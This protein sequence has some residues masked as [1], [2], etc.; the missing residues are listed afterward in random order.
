MFQKKVFSVFTL[1]NPSKGQFKIFID[2]LKVHY[3]LCSI[4]EL[5]IGG[6]N[7]SYC[8][9]IT[10][11]DG[12]QDN[13]KLL[14]IIK[15][16]QIPTTI[17]VCPEIIKSNVP[18]WF[19][20]SDSEYLKTIDDEMRIK[21]INDLDSSLGKNALSI[22]YITAMKKYVSFQSHTLTHPILTHCTS[23]KSKN[24]IAESKNQLQLMIGKDINGFAYPAGYYN[25]EVIDQV[26][27][28][29]YQYAFTTDHGYN[30]NKTDIY[31][32]KR[33]SINDDFTEKELAV[34]VSGIWGF[35]KKIL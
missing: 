21:I 35:I 24:E 33:I 27:S 10:I 11:D 8:I 9:G 5:L 29:G 28:A 30:N 25:D 7:Q 22:N 13:F 16:E 34:K 19:T 17:F 20:Y 15:S 1:H 4:E 32:L 14:E 31:N 3:T 18:F 12:Y 26:K 2:Y 6:K 23:I